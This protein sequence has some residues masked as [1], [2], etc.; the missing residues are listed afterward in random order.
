MKD[1]PLDQ[2][3]NLSMFEQIDSLSERSSE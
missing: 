2:E 3:I 1:T